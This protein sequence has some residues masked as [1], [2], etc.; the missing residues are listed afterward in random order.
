MMFYAL[1]KAIGSFRQ[2]PVTETIEPV[3]TPEPEVPA[4][5]TALLPDSL[6]GVNIGD[7]LANF[8]IDPTTFK[9]ILLGFYR[10]NQETI[11]KMKAA[12]DS[13]DWD[14]LQQMAHSLKGSAANIGADS[15][16]MAAKVLEEA[17]EDETLRPPEAKVVDD[18][19]TA[20]NEVLESLGSLLTPVEDKAEPEEKITIDPAQALPAIDRLAE[21]LPLA[22]P[23]SIRRSMQL[24]RQYLGNTILQQLENH[25]NDYKYDEALEVLR[26]IQKQLK[27]ES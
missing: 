25:I 19:E 20:M 26:K 14:E 15:L 3:S 13:E 16:H 2:P 22:D 17:C 10:N 23:E 7:T 24:V 6:P 1:W 12:F 9:R 8:N 27:T 4:A 18:L 11:T 5:E 21:A